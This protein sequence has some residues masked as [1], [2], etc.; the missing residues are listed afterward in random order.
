MGVFPKDENGGSLHSGD[1]VLFCVY[2]PVLLLVANP[3]RT[4]SR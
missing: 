1:P 2:D 4:L 3:G